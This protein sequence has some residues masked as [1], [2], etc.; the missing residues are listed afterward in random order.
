MSDDQDRDRDR[1]A[2]IEGKLDLIG[3][4]LTQVEKSNSDH[5]ERI[6]ILERWRYSLPAGLGVAGALA[7]E[8][9][10]KFQGG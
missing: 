6:R 10:S 8:L 5:E 9:I 1:L 2:R 7:V 4:Q 3:L